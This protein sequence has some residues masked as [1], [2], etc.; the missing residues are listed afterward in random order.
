ML[1]H[2]LIA[3]ALALVGVSLPSRRGV[4][5]RG[6]ASSAGAL[7]WRASLDGGGAIFSELVLYAEALLRWPYQ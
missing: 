3:A 7:R 2:A 5:K 6:E 4:L 1:G